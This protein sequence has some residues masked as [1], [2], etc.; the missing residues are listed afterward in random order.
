MSKSQILKDFDDCYVHV[1]DVIGDKVTN[2]IQ[3]LKLGKKLFGEKFKAVYCADDNIRLNNDQC[4]I[5]NTDP[6]TKS[7]SHWCGLYKYRNVYYIFDSFGRNIHKLTKFFKNKRWVEIEHRRVES[8]KSSNCGEL[9]MTFL[10]IFDKYK[11]K[12]KG[13]I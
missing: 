8:F 2:N 1:C 3:L 11:L 9:S 6:H 7:G 13:V 10:I 12:C 5:V 4:C